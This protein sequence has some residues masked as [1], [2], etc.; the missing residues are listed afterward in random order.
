MRPGGFLAVLFAFLAITTVYR[1]LQ[2]LHAQGE[3]STENGNGS[4]NPFQF[5]TQQDSTVDAAKRILGQLGRRAVTLPSAFQAQQ[6]AS[7]RVARASMI[8]PPGMYNSDVKGIDWE[9]L[10]QTLASRGTPQ[11]PVIF[12]LVYILPMWL[13]VFMLFFVHAPGH[14]EGQKLQPAAIQ[15]MA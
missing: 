10:Q 12:N 14:T 5:A 3:I 7:L 15:P 8:A 6:D 4:S 13:E 11:T 9:Q 1:I 2:T